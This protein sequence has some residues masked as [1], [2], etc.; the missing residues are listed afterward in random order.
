MGRSTIKKNIIFCYD[1][2]ITIRNSDQLWLLAQDL[3][4]TKLTTS[5]TDRGDDLQLHPIPR[6]N[7][8]GTTAGERKIIVLGCG[9]G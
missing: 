4:K 1:L 6:N 3:H 8:Q 5:S 2:A 7:W 9:H